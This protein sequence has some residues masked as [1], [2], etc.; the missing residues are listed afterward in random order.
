VERLYHLDA[1]TIA[2]KQ[3]SPL[4]LH[5]VDSPDAGWVLDA[6][7]FYRDKHSDFGIAVLC[8]SADSAG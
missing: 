5:N 4:T 8:A 7:Q 6:L 2:P 3:I 1:A